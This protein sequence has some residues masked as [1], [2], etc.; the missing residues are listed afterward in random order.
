MSPK[1]CE[2]GW[3]GSAEAFPL[4]R[5]RELDVPAGELT[6]PLPPL[7][8]VDKK[9]MDLFHAASR[10]RSSATTFS[11]CRGEV[12]QNLHDPRLELPFFSRSLDS[13]CVKQNEPFAYPRA[14][15]GRI[16]VEGGLWGQA[17]LQSATGRFPNCFRQGCSAE[18]RCEL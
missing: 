5:S 12:S 18:L 2:V 17:S 7:G 11:G 10:I 14:A 1:S 3:R 6:R 8:L 15:G 4:E 16:S 13:V 9:T